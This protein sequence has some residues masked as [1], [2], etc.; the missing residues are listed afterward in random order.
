MIILSEIAVEDEQ[1]AEICSHD[2]ISGY[3]SAFV[4][5]TFVFKDGEYQEDEGEPH[6]T[7]YEM[8]VSCFTCDDCGKTLDYKEMQQRET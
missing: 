1:D 7:E 4:K 5:T 8:D 6:S 2:N 3:M